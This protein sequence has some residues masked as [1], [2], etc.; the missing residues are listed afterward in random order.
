[1]AEIAEPPRHPLIL[2][3]NERVAHAGTGRAKHHYMLWDGFEE[4]IEPQPLLASAATE[5]L[6]AVLIDQYSTEAAREAALDVL[7]G[8]NDQPAADVAGAI[9]PTVIGYLDGRA[10]RG[11]AIELMLT[12]LREYAPVHMAALVAAI[13]EETASHDSS[14]RA[15]AAAHLGSLL[16]TSWNPLWLHQEHRQ[17]A[18]LL[19]CQLLNDSDWSVREAA[20]DTQTDEELELSDRN[21]HISKLKLACSRDQQRVLERG[22][23]DKS[24]QPD[25]RADLHGYSQVGIRSA[26]KRTKLVTCERSFGQILTNNNSTLNV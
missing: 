25:E 15:S 13:T 10:A 1:M 8:L 24:N 19:F 4:W 21:A 20:T 26:R 11:P 22:L 18:Q 17:R 3:P 23:E 2:S 14:V 7:A 12:G 9:V 5:Q 16:R 6:T